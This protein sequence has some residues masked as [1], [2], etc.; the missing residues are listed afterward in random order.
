MTYYYRNLKAG[1]VATKALLDDR[2]ELSVVKASAQ[3]VNNSA[4]LV[5][6]TALTLALAANATYHVSAV[7]IFSGPTAADWKSQWSA[8]SGSAGT[9]FAHGPALSVSSVRSTTINFASVSIGSSLSYGTDATE[10]SMVHE[11]LWM[12]TSGTS[13]SLT[14]QWAQ[15]SATVGSTR[16]EAGSYMTAYRVV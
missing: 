10:N 6:D 12:T 13:G 16:V 1:E 9:R 14:L 3:T 2:E 4:T 7:V 5:S 15:N 11:Q 8:P